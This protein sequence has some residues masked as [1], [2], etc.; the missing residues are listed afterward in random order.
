[1]NTHIEIIK[2][3]E[4]LAPSLGGTGYLSPTRSATAKEIAAELNR[5]RGEF[6]DLPSA[7]F[8]VLRT[9]VSWQNH[10]PRRRLRFNGTTVSCRCV[11]G[12]REWWFVSLH[13]TQAERL[14]AI[15]G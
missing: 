2:P 12:I 11:G 8:K 5:V 9:T 3:S 7:V 4:R 15:G 10:Y 13:V 6:P 14:M 1:M